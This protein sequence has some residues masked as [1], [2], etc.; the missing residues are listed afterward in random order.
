[1][2]VAAGIAQPRCSAGSRQATAEIDE[3]GHQHADAGGD[4]RQPA[5][6]PARQAADEKLALDLQPDQQEERGHQAVVDPGM[7]RHRPEPGLQRVMIGAGGG[8]V[9]GEQGQRRRADQDQPARGFGLEEAADGRGWTA[10]D[11][12]IG[13]HPALLGGLRDA[14]N[15]SPVNGFS[16]SR[17]C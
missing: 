3:G 11:R 15:P 8:A 13:R 9:G 6:V 16:K 17:R 10:A 5:P 4:Q 1:M 14:G 7:R 12:R 2:S